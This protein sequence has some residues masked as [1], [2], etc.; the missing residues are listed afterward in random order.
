MHHALERVA[1]ATLASDRPAPRIV[2]LR[3]ADQAM[4]TYEDDGPMHE[5]PI[6]LMLYRAHGGRCTAFLVN[7]AAD[8]AST[9]VLSQERWSQ[10]LGMSEESRCHAKE[11][12]IPPW[13]VTIL[14]DCELCKAYN[15]ADHVRSNNRVPPGPVTRET[16]TAA[17]WT[18]ARERAGVKKEANRKRVFT[19]KVPLSLLEL[20]D[21]DPRA[22]YAFYEPVHLSRLIPN[23]SH[24]DES[25]ITLNMSGIEDFAHVFANDTLIATSLYP[26]PSSTNVAETPPRSPVSILSYSRSIVHTSPASASSPY[27]WGVSEMRVNI[28]SHV[29]PSSLPYTRISILAGRLGTVN[30]GAHFFE[31]AKMGIGGVALG[32][33]GSAPLPVE[34]WDNQGWAPSPPNSSA[35]GACDGMPAMKWLRACIAVPT[36]TTMVGLSLR[37]MS[38]GFA[39]VNGFALGRYYLI[40]AQYAPGQGTCLEVC[41]GAEEC[42]AHMGQFQPWSCLKG[43]GSPT[44]HVYKV[45]A[46]VLEE[47]FK[48]STSCAKGTAEVLLFEE[49]GGDPGSVSLVDASAGFDA[50]QCSQAP[51]AGAVSYA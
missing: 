5:L 21:G 15:T 1:H 45:P 29:R 47:S 11:L 19:S 10:I 18:C 42:N 7:D 24:S 9:A 37:G 46:E 32:V 51:P 26:P 41:E 23:M 3:K 44:Q 38:K 28:S 36:N 50:A 33:G 17:A 25:A 20:I 43:C 40:N 12:F 35:Y 49:L 2:M 16:R 30:Y 39:M 8:N 34:A 31:D 4:N 27:T 6:T 13:S 22:D 48:E 14:E